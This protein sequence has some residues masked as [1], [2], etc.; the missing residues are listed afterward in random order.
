M[1]TDDDHRLVRATEAAGVDQEE[2][3]L[4]HL[5][6]AVRELAASDAQAHAILSMIDA[7]A[8]HQ[9]TS[10][11]RYRLA[12]THVPLLLA[13]GLSGRADAGRSVAAAATAIYLAADAL[14][15]LLDGDV[16]KYWARSPTPAEIIATATLLGAFG[17]LMV[18][19][20][21]GAA[22]SVA[23]QDE[24]GTTL[25]AMSA[26]Q[27]D[28]VSG[29]GP[30]LSIDE[31]R[32]M[33]ARKSGAMLAGFAALGALA[34]DASEA[35]VRQARE[36][37]HGLAM[38]RQITSDIS[39]LTGSSGGSDFRNTVPT[40]PLAYHLMTVP[41]GD[42]KMFVDR[43]QDAANDTEMARALAQEICGG[44]GIQAAVVEAE[45]WCAGAL[46]ALVDLPLDTVVRKGLEE[47]VED[48]SPMAPFQGGNGK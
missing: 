36:Y 46:S 4:H 8:R 45:L 48:A 22:R 13:H 40:I 3:T 9:G 5:R 44:R 18:A 26:G 6:H 16:P 7:L 28:D 42:Q 11:Q 20:I 21:A 23:L 29:V 15:D 27:L 25:L 19:R 38:A 32:L 10:N 30:E 12:A 34:V 47:L 37:G 35:Q 33:V 2:A 24:L 39:E 1:T 17:Q 41:E 14:D 43:M 31:V